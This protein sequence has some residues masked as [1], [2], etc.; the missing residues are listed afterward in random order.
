MHRNANIFDLFHINPTPYKTT[1]LTRTLPESLG[2]FRRDPGPLYSYTHDYYT[3]FGLQYFRPEG[4][5]R[6]LK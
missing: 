3:V 1:P 5:P 2:T 4:L 6:L